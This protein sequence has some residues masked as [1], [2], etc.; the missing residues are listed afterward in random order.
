MKMEM[1]M[2]MEIEIEIEIEIITQQIGTKQIV[3]MYHMKQIL[4]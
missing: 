2:E 1:E 4:R 3:I